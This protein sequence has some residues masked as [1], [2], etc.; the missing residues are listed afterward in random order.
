ME[1]TEIQTAQTDETLE[2]TEPT[3]E[4]QEPKAEETAEVTEDINALKEELEKAKANARKWEKRAKENKDSQPLLAQTKEE[5][6]QIK[7]EYE[8]AQ[9]QLTELEKQK[10]RDDLVNRISKETGL[11]KTV[12]DS[13]KGDTEEELLAV[14]ETVKESIGTIPLYP[15]SK[16]DGSQVS[17]VKLSKEEIFAIKD[18]VERRKAIA[19]NLLKE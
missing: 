6:E 13:M 11:P 18:P 7:A 17:P 2:T 8:Q 1:N 5:L 12:I 16:N 19:E 14:A 3:V 4:E 9:S 15:T 10:Q